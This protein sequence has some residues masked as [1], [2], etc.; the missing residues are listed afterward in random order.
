MDDN[1]ED[2]Y[3]KLYVPHLDNQFHREIIGLAKAKTDRDKHYYRGR[4][5][6]LCELV[7]E[8]VGDYEKEN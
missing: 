7:T 1:Y 5:A 6:M 8:H 3:M 4:L 2:Y